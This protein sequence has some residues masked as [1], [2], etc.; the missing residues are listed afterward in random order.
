MIPHYK[1]FYFMWTINKKQRK[2]NLDPNIFRSQIF[3]FKQQQLEF[4]D[5]SYF[6]LW[7]ASEL[8]F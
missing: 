4:S 5:S 3:Q 7:E 8:N 2:E 6:K 1:R